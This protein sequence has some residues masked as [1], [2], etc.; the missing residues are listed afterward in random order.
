L[1][2]LCEGFRDLVVVRVTNER[3][4]RIGYHRKPFLIPPGADEGDFATVDDAPPED[5]DVAIC[6]ILGP[7]DVTALGFLARTIDG[8]GVGLSCHR[9]FL[10]SL[11]PPDSYIP[12]RRSNHQQRRTIVTFFPGISVMR[13][14][15]G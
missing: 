7:F 12:M 2:C 9:F 14:L 11:L 10:Q 15:R 1:W 5:F 6:V 4:E 3:L 13:C 8:V